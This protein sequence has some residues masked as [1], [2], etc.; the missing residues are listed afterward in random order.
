ASHNEALPRKERTPPLAL[1]DC[2][3]R[4]QRFSGAVR[5]S[6]RGRG[7]VRFNLKSPFHH[8]LLASLTEDSFDASPVRSDSCGKTAAR[9]VANRDGH[10][11]RLRCTWL[12]IRS[13]L[14]RLCGPNQRREH[15]V[16]NRRAVVSQV[17]DHSS[18]IDKQQDWDY[19]GLGSMVPLPLADPELLS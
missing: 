7:P 13:T 14:R 18:R 16:H 15:P 11:A 2:A 12:E 3:L 8:G 9:C 1:F 4:R 17:R 19:I 5:R 10:Y 6:S